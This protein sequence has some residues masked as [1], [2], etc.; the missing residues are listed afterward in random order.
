MAWTVVFKES[1]LD[2]LRWFGR[3]NGRLLF[4]AIEERLSDAPTALSRNLKTLRPNPIAQREL[5]L[6]GRYRVLFNVAADAGVVT[7]LIVGEKRGDALFVRGEEYRG[8]HENRPP[9]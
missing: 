5:R 9:E 4:K 8:H 1:V 7:V 2:D 6:F 3:K